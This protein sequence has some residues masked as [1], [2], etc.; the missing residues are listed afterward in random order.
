MAL[1]RAINFVVSRRAYVAQ[2]GPYAGQPWTRLFNPSVPGWTNVNPYPLD[3]DVPKARALA[4]GHFR[5]G[6]ITILYRSS[7]TT[8][9]AQAAIVR[10]DLIDLGFD[11]ANI[12]MRPADYW[13]FDPMKNADIGVSMGWC[14][15]YPDPYEWI[16]L[17]LSGE[18]V[19]DQW[20]VNY[21]KMDLPKWNARM[22]AAAK[23]VGRKRFKVYGQLDL[24]IMRQVAPMA[25]E[26][27]YNN[28]YLFS[29]R[30]DPK[31]LVYQGIYQDWSI[32]AL[33]LK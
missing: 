24:D 2:A 3:R 14:S 32:P 18:H 20:S 4:A 25:V 26:R 21:S 19:H 13:D 22:E 30:V 12:T 16:N 31:S 5:D 29:D 1:R 11:P 23:L 8:N 15:D 27:T 6:Q 10:Q 33:A 28:R 17:L 7:G 9:P